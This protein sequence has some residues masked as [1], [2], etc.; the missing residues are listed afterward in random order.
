MMN[1]KFFFFPTKNNQS[2]LINFY[3]YEMST[4]A[5]KAIK[6]EKQFITMSY[7]YDKELKI[8]I[9]IFYFSFIFN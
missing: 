5:K 6:K 8:D 2:F 7:Y 3:F 1:V 4:F 9:L